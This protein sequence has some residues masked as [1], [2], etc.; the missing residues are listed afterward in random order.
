M[1][2]IWDFWSWNSAEMVG[3][4]FTAMDM[5]LGGVGMVTLVLG[6]IGVVNIMLVP[7]SERTREIGIRMAVGAR[8]RD[9]LWQFLVEA[10]TLSALGEWW[11]LRWA[12]ASRRCWRRP[13][14]TPNIRC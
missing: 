5:F 8:G 1:E 2:W 4:I 7:V 14:T 3:M 10:V 6:A 9:I 11:G 13:P 12:S